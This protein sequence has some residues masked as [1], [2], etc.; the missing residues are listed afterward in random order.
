MAAKNTT[1]QSYPWLDAFA[2]PAQ[3]A[4]LSILQRLNTIEGKTGQPSWAAPVDAGGNK[5]VGLADPSAATDAV[6]KQYADAHYGPAVVKQNLQIG[7][8]NPLNI[9]TLLGA[10]GQTFVGL[11]ADR[12]LRH[13][14]PDGTLFYELDRQVLYVVSAG[15]W[16]YAASFPGIG[17]YVLVASLPGD[18]G[19]NDAG[20]PAWGIDTGLLY[21][22]SGGTWHKRAG[23]IRDVYANKTA[24][25]FA[26]QFDAGVIFV[27]TNRGGQAWITDYAAGDWVL[28]K[29]WGSPFA[30]TLGTLPVLGANDAGFLINATDYDR[31]YAWSGAAWADVAGSPTRKMYVDFHG[32]APPTAGWVIADGG[33]YNISTATAGTVGFVTANVANYYVRG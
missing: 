7:G 16:F 11:H 13:G 17:S 29:G 26:N 32:I 14:D 6:T 15:A 19:S 9:Q 3:N 30:C 4:I 12:V 23:I 1:A 27:A 33:T 18:L 5:L 20:F 21:V 25:P 2:G 8:S 24:L 10:A 22:W 28:L 31:Q